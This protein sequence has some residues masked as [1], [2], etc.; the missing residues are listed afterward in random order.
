MTGEFKKRSL[1][2]RT[3]VNVR[4]VTNAL[5]NPRSQAK[6]WNTNVGEDRGWSYSWEGRSREIEEAAALYRSCLNFDRR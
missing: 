3:I 4:G 5:A 1:A 6:G 2:E